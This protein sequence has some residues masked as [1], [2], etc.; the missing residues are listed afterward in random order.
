MSSGES[1]FLFLIFLPIDEKNET[2]KK[3]KSKDDDNSKETTIATTGSESDGNTALTKNDVKKEAKE[4]KADDENGSN[5]PIDQP[6]TAEKESNDAKDEPQT[7]SQL[8]SGIEQQQPV[9][10]A[11]T[12]PPAAEVSTPSPTR[13]KPPPSLGPNEGSSQES[14]KLR[15][16]RDRSASPVAV[17]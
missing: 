5:L 15:K 10:L 8:P 1:K 17:G 7:T 12:L 3:E 4:A 2:T 9:S 16:S 11:P 13:A 6:T 14:P